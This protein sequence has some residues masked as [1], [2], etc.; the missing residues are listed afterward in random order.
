MANNHSAKAWSFGTSDNWGEKFPQ[1]SANSQKITPINID[2]S[3]V[4][5]CNATCRLA[6]RFKE[7][8]C[9]TQYKNNIPTI[10]FDPGCLLKF[11]EEYFNLK[12]MTLHHPSMHT[13]NGSH[14]D[15]E[16]LLYYNKNPINER[17]GGV[18][19]SIL[20]KRGPDHG[21]INNFFNQ[22]INQIPVVD[23]ETEQ[24]IE[25]DKNWSPK[26][27]IPDSKA[28]FYYDGSLP[29]PPCTPNWTIVVFEQSMAISENVIN[30]LK[31]ILG[32]SNRN[33][34]E[35]SN[36]PEGMT[37]FYNSNND[38]Q[39]TV[40]TKDIESKPEKELSDEMMKLNLEKQKGYLIRN[41]L[42]VKG[43][44][45]TVILVIV[46]YV[47]IKVA[48]YFIK[49]DI[50]NSFII[51]QVI[52]KNKR[53]EEIKRK[54]KEAEMEESGMMDPSMGGMPPMDMPP[55]GGL[56]PPPG[57]DPLAGLLPPPLPK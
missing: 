35:V 14:Y 47:A 31:Y 53:D 54:Q 34:R 45:L 44:I 15:M 5:P 2:T 49:N 7:S 33:V 22:F 55:A 27:I 28:F 4:S 10:L 48:S 43:I 12:K 3:D 51:S 52:K 40:K 57:G 20:T 13:I 39:D 11:K 30:T 17:D 21:D 25:V 56:P 26:V 23:T 16:I 18:I 37:V 41:K 24:E 29:Y 8:K 38:F 50:I 19:L 1:C 32:D 6:L 42:Y 46:I 9:Y 36:K